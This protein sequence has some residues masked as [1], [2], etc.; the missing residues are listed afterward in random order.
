MASQRTRT[1]IAQ[2]ASQMIA[3]EIDLIEG[4]RRIS[5]LAGD[6]DDGRADVF[7]VFAGVDSETDD[8][9]LGAKRKLWNELSLARKDEEKKCYLLEAEDVILDACVRVLE[10]LEPSS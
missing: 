1:T 3:K 4:C 6:L 10:Y 7:T 2:I 5:R 8:L 9:P